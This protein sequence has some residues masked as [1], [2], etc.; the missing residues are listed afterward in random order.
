MPKATKPTTLRQRI[1]NWFSP[2]APEPAKRAYMAARNTRT[3]GGFGSG[4]TTS[5]DSE[6]SMG[7]TDTPFAV[8][9]EKI[10]P[11]PTATFPQFSAMNEPVFVADTNPWLYKFISLVPP[12]MFMWLG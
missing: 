5:A 3:T 9:A 7:L 10:P 1:A 6:L 12:R 8:E 4:G 11:L 2:S